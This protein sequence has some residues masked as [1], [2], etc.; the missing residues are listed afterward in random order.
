[1][2]DRL[3]NICNILIITTSLGLEAACGGG[4]SSDAPTTQTA[5]SITAD[6]TRVDQ[7][8]FSPISV[9]AYLKDQ[10]GAAI[11]GKT[12]SL[13]I[14]QGVASPITNNGDG[15]YSF[16][17]TPSSSGSYPIQIQYGGAT[18]SRKAVVTRTVAVGSGISQ[19]FEVPG[20]MINTDGYQDGITITPD[21]NYLF[22]QYGPIY[23]SGLASV[24][25]ICHSASYSLYDILGCGPKADSGFVFNTIGPYNDASRPRF[26]TGNISG[27]HLVP[28]SLYVSGVTNGLP[29]FPTVFYG[30]K[31][32]ADGTFGEP[33]KVAF[34]DVRGLQ[35]PFGL[36][37]QMTSATTANFLVAWN[38]PF[39]DIGGDGKPDIYQGT[40]TL[41]QDKNLGDV[42]YSGESYA[43]IAPYI[44]PVTFASHAG[45]QGNPHL[46]YDTS[47]A[48]RSIWT[49]DEQVS[50]NIS[51][52]VLTSGAFPTGTWNL[53]T[54]PSVINTSASESQPFFTGQRLYFTRDNKIVYHQYLG[55]GGNDYGLNSSWGPEHVLLVTGDT[56]IGTL[57]GFG[58]PTIGTYGGKTYLYFAMVKVRSQSPSGLFD[59]NLAAGYVEIH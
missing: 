17:V 9:R 47:G 13:T 16:T 35:G 49:D 45:V 6:F 39:N 36:S 1:M 18:Y 19:P 38:N 4:S 23:F 57:F 22:M 53:V 8:G 7:I 20:D 43:S 44:T 58:E 42:V 25:T 33:F 2:R 52:Y 55:S 50:H 29:V 56:A 12:L 34:N 48:V 24:G 32:E 26:P 30:F 27:G 15:S 54:L 11:S 46:Y 5:Y 14:P 59:Y 31:R 37:F 41:G 21:G 51:V 3:K 28:T 10:S 40:L